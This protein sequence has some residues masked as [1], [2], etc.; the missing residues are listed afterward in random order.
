ML[1]ELIMVNKSGG[2]IYSR[3]L[4]QTGSNLTDND[5]LRLGSTF[6]SLHAIATQVAPVRCSGIDSIDSDGCKLNCFSS[7]T[8][9]KIV[10][11]STLNFDAESFLLGIYELYTDFVMKVRKNISPSCYVP[12]Q[13]SN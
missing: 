6:H 2:V 7:K 13:F 12:V 3:K 1:L 9:M 10:V 11:I 5:Y 4:S 8:G